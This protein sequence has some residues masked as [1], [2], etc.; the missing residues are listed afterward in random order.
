MIAKARP[1]GIYIDVTGMSEIPM[2]DGSFL[3]PL[4]AIR[5]YDDTGNVLGASLTQEGDYNYGREPIRELRNGIIEGIDRMINLYNHYL[6]LV[7]DAIGVPIGVDASTPHPDTAVGVQEQLALN[8][9]TATRHILNASLSITK[10]LAK[11][12][13]LRMKDVFK[14]SDLKQVYINSIGKI[15]FEALKA[16]EKFHLHDLG[17]HIE[18]KPDQQEKQALQA[19]IQNSLNKAEI[20]VEDS[21]DIRKVGN[22]KLASELLKV[23]RK[24]R[25]QEQQEFELKK[26]KE[27]ADANAQ[28]A[29][30]VSQAK[31]QEFQVKAQSDIMVED[32]K[33]ANKEKL[34][35]VEKDLKSKLMGEEFEYNMALK[36]GELD[37]VM[38]RDK[39]KEDAKTFRQDRNNT[40]AAKLI[41]MRNRNTAPPNFESREVSMSDGINLGEM[42]V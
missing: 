32:A 37:T 21:I 13:G 19:D 1:N 38:M 18:L 25:L 33:A 6:N 41:E 17:I 8:S 35:Y 5:I 29:I 15:N 14:Y 28:A 16:L 42:E 3:T 11:G 30:A 34:L 4:E 27:S 24:K 40:Q 9:N 12:L 23:R 22:L 39:F 26:I 2:G 20:T 10:R 7:R 31:S 36:T